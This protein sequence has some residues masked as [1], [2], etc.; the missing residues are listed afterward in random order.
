HN[1]T[2]THRR[3]ETVAP[4]KAQSEAG[5][6]KVIAE[7][8]AVIAQYAAGMSMAEI[9]RAYGVGEAWLTSRFNEWDVP[10]RD[11]RAAGIARWHRPQ[12]R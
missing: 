7:R 10:R 4:S 6:N 11:P 5:R 9:A 3:Q 12:A 8:E 1:Q 2:D